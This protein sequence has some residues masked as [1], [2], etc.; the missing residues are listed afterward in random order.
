MEVGFDGGWGRVMF[1][2]GL[3]GRESSGG[4]GPGFIYTLEVFFTAS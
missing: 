2:G 3:G 4:R 1:V